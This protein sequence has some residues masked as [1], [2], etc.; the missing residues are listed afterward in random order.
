MFMGS[1]DN[2]VLRILVKALIELSYSTQQ[3]GF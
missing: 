3:S 1:L 2:N